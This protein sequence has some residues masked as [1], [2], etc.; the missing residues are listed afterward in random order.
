VI[1]GLTPD[2]MRRTRK[3][4]PSALPSE[5]RSTSSFRTVSWH[6]SS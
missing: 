6:G 2:L 5:P 3:S 4:R 1:D